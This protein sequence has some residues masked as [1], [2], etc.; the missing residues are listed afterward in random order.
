MKLE[1]E[2]RRKE[3]EE[4]LRKENEENER[5]ISALEMK[6]AAL[7]LDKRRRQEAEEREREAEA[8]EERAR[9]R[10]AEL[11]SVQELTEIIEEPVAD[12]G[13]YVPEVYDGSQRADDDDER[14]R[15]LEAQAEEPDADYVADDHQDSP[16]VVSPKLDHADETPQREDEFDVDVGARDVDDGNLALFGSRL[17]SGA[18]DERMR[19]SRQRRDYVFPPVVDKLH[20]GLPTYAYK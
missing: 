2:K 5:L 7:E 14:L 18:L 1:Q 17:H 16:T 6:V 15:P 13:D 11:A 9:R 12:V 20:K 10:N 3:R 19:Y 4:E 8:E